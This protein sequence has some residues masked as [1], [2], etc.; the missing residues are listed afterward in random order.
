MSERRIIRHSCGASRRRARSFVVAAAASFAIFACS[1]VLGELPP[2][3]SAATKDA[4]VPDTRPEADSAAE[5]GEVDALP[6][7]DAVEAEAE[8]GESGAVDASDDVACTTPTAW[9]ADEDNDGHGRSDD[10]VMACRKPPRRASVSGDCND[11]NALVHPG[12][13]AFIGVSYL[14]SNRVQ[15]F[16][17]DC[18]GVENE[19]PSQQKSTT[20]CGLL[21][22]ALCDSGS[23]YAPTARIGLG[24][25][26][27]CGSSVVTVCRYALALLVCQSFS[28]TAPRPF[29]CR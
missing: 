19:D 29:G 13:T 9:Y 6:E 26:R 2:N 12:Q 20:S 18:S 27:Y 4:S 8:A 5:S 17:Y 23:G 15:S 3:Q 10:V 14:N 11:G 25:S 22:L 1:L 28:E 16:D 7:N 24:V 21:D